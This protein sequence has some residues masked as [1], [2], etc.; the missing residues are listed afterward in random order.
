[1]AMAVKVARP[2]RKIEKWTY[3]ELKGSKANEGVP[4]AMT[5][6]AEFLNRTGI[7]INP[8]F[9]PG[10][11]MSVPGSE[12]EFFAKVKEL[13]SSHQFVVVLLPRKDVAIYN[14]V[15]RA[16]DITFGVHT[17]CCVAEKFLSTKGQ[18]G[19]F[20]NVGLKVNLKF[21]GTNHNI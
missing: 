7:P 12:K 4:Q 21:G 13:M 16:A 14:M 3:L 11:S 2:C 15:K 20:A 19:Y 1:G 5:A 17:V 10:M 9:S 18:L 8:R 6:F